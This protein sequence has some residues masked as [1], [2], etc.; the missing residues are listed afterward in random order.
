MDPP[1][2]SKNPSDIVLAP[3]LTLDLKD[4]KNSITFRTVQDY[5][6]YLECKCKRKRSGDV[7]LL[8]R[9]YTTGKDETLDVTVK[10]YKKV[11]DVLKE[12]GK[13]LTPNLWTYAIAWKFC[14]TCNDSCLCYNRR[15]ECEQCHT[16]LDD[17]SRLIHEDLQ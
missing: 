8:Y 1:K 3:R 2:L 15:G 14:P 9:D 16:V 7:R 11:I 5:V 10:D 13:D 17:P 12:H 4:I 6:S